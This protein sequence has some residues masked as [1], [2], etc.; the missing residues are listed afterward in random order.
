M[1]KRWIV[2]LFVKSKSLIASESN[3]FDLLLS[4][5]LSSLTELAGVLAARQGNCLDWVVT[6]GTVSRF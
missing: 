3:K 2:E 4:Q 5:Y 6:E 1:V